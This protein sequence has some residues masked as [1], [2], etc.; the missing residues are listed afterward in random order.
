VVDRIAVQGDPAA[1]DLAVVHVEQ[2]GQRAQQGRLAR[3]VRA[4]Q[5]DDP[6]FRNPQAHAAQHQHHVVVDH[7][8]VVRLEHQAPPGDVGEAISM[9]PITGLP[10]AVRKP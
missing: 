6:P 1:G 8:K 2:A 10:T 3:S 4:E 7:L 9:T 5:G